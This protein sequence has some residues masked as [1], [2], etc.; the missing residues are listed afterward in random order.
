MGVVAGIDWASETHVCCVI[1]DAGSVMERFDV[2]HDA[3]SLRPAVTPARF[4]VRLALD[5]SKIDSNVNRYHRSSI[6][7]PM[8]LRPRHRVPPAS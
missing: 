4:P 3:A 7:R 2:A 8:W 1:D 5:I 6:W